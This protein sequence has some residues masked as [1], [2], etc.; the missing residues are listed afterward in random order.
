[1][2]RYLTEFVG[3]FFLVL[4]I[5]LAVVY[6]GPLAPLAIGL[7]LMVMVYMG[8]SVSGGHYNPAVSLG[9]LLSRA[10]PASDFVP[11]VVAQ[12]AGAVAAGSVGYFLTG[13][14]VAPAVGP[15]SMLW[16][17]VLVEILFTFALVLVVLNTACTERTKGNS[18]F[19]AAIGL[20]V[21]V[22]AFAGGSISGGAFNPAVGLG[23]NGVDWIVHNKLPEQA[24]IYL[25]GP[26]VG[27]VLASSV[28][29]IQGGT[30]KA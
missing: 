5:A 7:S 18:Y 16:G 24:W 11:Y 1:M 9:A 20:T 21:A 30:G 6:A 12:L 10:M 8:G 23:M 28:F 15:T 27:A 2:A 17:A 4:T 19:G 14:A 29:R 26:G 13:K 22:G 25:V 3:T